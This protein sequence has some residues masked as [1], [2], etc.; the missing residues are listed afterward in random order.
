MSFVL[1]FKDPVNAA[2]AR[3]LHRHVIQ[4]PAELQQSSRVAP[5]LTWTYETNAP[6]NQEGMRII[7]PKKNMLVSLDVLN[8]ALSTYFGDEYSYKL[9]L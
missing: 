8:K 5:S 7:D 1:H 9:N 3:T 6:Y 4:V 2:A